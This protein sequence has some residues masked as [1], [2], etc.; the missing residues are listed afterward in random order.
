[1]SKF[2]RMH[3]GDDSSDEDNKQQLGTIPKKRT[4]DDLLSQKNQI[5]MDRLIKA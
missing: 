4:A 5:L 3:G 2:D 1:M